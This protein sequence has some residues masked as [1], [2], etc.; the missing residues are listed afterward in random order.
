MGRGIALLE[1]EEEQERK[2]AFAQFGYETLIIWEHELK[3]ET[4]ML[5]KIESW[6]EG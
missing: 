1:L 6:V 3:N 5:N 2:E 4:A